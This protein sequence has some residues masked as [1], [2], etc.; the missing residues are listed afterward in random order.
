M[1]ITN[2]I[3][4]SHFRRHGVVALTL[5]AAAVFTTSISWFMVRAEEEKSSDR[6]LSA[7]MRK[8][9]EASS[10]I[11]EGLTTEDAP[12]IQK[13]ANALLDISKAEMW[14]VLI[15]T[16]YREHNADY[17]TTVRKL[18]EAAEKSNFDNAALQWFDVTKSCI[19][20][21]QEVRR[22]KTARR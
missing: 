21:H 22:S 13:G 16:D 1:K 5:M 17:R 15:D 6:S 3:M 20:C 4:C 12:L 7:M 9:L 2:P 19:E 8:K 18:A 11:L 10:Q 14:K